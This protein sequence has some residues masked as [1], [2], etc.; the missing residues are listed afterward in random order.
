M[1]GIRRVK[2]TKGGTSSGGSKIYQRILWSLLAIALLG[3]T[4]QAQTQG[5]APAS[6]RD[7]LA[8]SGDH[9]GQQVLLNGQRLPLAWSQW[10]AGGTTRIGISDTALSRQLGIELLST[11]DPQRQP[12]GWFNSPSGPPPVLEARQFGGYRYLDVSELLQRSTSQLQVNGDTLYIAS[13]PAQIKEI[14]TGK[15]PWG[16]RFVVDLDRPAFWRVQQGREEALIVLEAIADAG[17]SD[18]FPSA[19]LTEDEPTNESPLFVV[20]PKLQRTQFKLKLPEGYKL[21]VASLGNPNRL[22]I[23][24]RLDALVER[25]IQWASGIDWHQQ[26]ISLG[27]SRFPVVWLELDP[28]AADLSL[29]P[30]W[31]NS[32]QMQGI[33]PLQQLAQ[34]QG[35]VAAINGGFFNRDR[36][37]PLGAIRRDQRWFSGAVLGRGAIGWDE[38][39][40]IKIDRLAQRGLLTT[41]RGERLTIEHLNSAYVQAGISRYTRAWGTTYTPLSDDEIIVIVINDRVI[42]QFPGGVAGQTPFPIPSE[43][44]LLTLRG[45]DAPTLATRLPVRVRLQLESTTTPSEFERY[46]HIISAGPLLLQNRQIVLDAEAEKFSSAFAKQAASRSAIATT[47]QGTL[48]LA[49]IHERIGGRGPTLLETAQIL[50]RLGAVDALNLDG[51][52]STS[53]YLGGQLIDRPPAT[54]ARVHNGLGVFLRR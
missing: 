21:R 53:L 39:G 34:Q 5:Q 47:S 24:L 45:D 48:I 50:Q 32:G 20:Q 14:R 3:T 30:I 51:G 29:T 40:N 17:M 22:V 10:Q 18:R 9:H 46:P 35:V 25:N 16:M 54:A 4:A 8:V 27:Q 43:G 49:A 23:D 33:F 42:Q 15:H 6:R 13:Q 37:L 7:S 19:L 1:K 12:V 52:S 44:Y 28:S 31:S 41:E 26:Y 11:N 36:Q 2:L 38:Q